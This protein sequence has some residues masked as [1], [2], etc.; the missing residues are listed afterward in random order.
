M[1]EGMTESTGVC[2]QDIVCILGMH[3]SGTS[4][5]T[6]IL[7]LIG[8]SLGPEQLLLQGGDAQPKGYWEHEQITNLNEAILARHGGSWDKPP[9]FPPGWETS[10]LLDD[11]KLRART[12]IQDAFANAEM[13][14][15]K[16]PRNC[17]TL[18]FWRQLL[19]EMRYVVCLRNPVDVAQSLAYRDSFSAEKSSSLW[20][21]YVNSALGNSDGQP[22]LTVFYEDLIDNWQRE[23][24][25]LAAFLGMP[26]RA[27]QVELKDKV[28]E[29]IEEGLRHYRTS[30][31]D[32]ATN[33]TIARRA[34]ALFMAQR[35]SVSLSRR[36][37]E[38]PDEMDEQIENVLDLLDQLSV[39]APN[40][41]DNLHGQ[42]GSQNAIQVLQKRL[43]ARDE[44]VKTISAQL[45]L[46]EQA[47]EDLARRLAEKDRALQRLES[48]ATQ[49][50]E[51]ARRMSAQLLDTETQLK[52]ITNTLGWRL[53]SRYGPIKYKYVLPV[54]RLFG[55]MR[56]EQNEDKPPHDNSQSRYRS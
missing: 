1:G 34:R 36:G 18:P 20:L 5:L 17:L 19:P 52:R 29:F 44:A 47:R 6:R 26:E 13:W 12:L 28:R 50:E 33:P 45:D 46:R 56:G 10:P 49:S 3:R 23:L 15:W 54:F 8:V 48:Q 40:H 41:A 35:I 39:E 22:R 30:I 9:I 4:L 43:A 31:V 37:T 24:R 2:N 7:N 38:A 14:G 42:P 51:N 16:D 27:E 21:S 11:L 25:R 53:L 55:K 32:T